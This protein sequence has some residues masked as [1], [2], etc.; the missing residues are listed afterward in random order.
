MAVSLQCTFNLSQ[1]S[2]SE[3]A[4]NPMEALDY[5]SSCNPIYA[6]APY[7]AVD[8]ESEPDV[9]DDSPYSLTDSQY[10]PSQDSPDSPKSSK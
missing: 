6:T 10:S 1:Q 2:S 4:N 3:P 9:V 8:G 5:D 7:R